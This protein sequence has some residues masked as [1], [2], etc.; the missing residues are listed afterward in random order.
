[1]TTKAL[2]L[3]RDGVINVD[4]AYVYRKEDFH[5]MDG[6]FDLC[7]AAKEKGYLIIIVTNQSGI[8]RGYY[9]ELDY[10]TL[11][12]HMLEEFER[13]AITIDDIYYCP[14]LQHEDRKPSPGM[15]LKAQKKHHIDLKASLMI[16]DK[17]RDLE[18]GQRA[19]IPV[20]LLIGDQPSP[21]IEPTARIQN[22]HQAL[23]WL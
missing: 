9:T 1:M 7:R 10:L 6:I 21:E 17:P 13:N 3:D 5:F 20:N 18:A 15:I 14:H 16:G 23:A 8:E 2:F 4:R 11:T 12:Q 22:L 19:G